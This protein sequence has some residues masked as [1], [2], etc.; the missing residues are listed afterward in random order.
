[1]MMAIQKREDTREKS[2][3]VEAGTLERNI[4]EDTLKRNMPHNLKIR[5]DTRG[6]NHRHIQK[7][8]V[9]MA[10]TQELMMQDVQGGTQ[11]N[12]LVYNNQ[13]GTRLLKVNMLTEMT[14]CMQSCVDIKSLP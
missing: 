6:M 4:L 3:I 2:T 5:E 11:S 9:H 1:M 13:L 10:E 12:L 7:R 8:G 14:R